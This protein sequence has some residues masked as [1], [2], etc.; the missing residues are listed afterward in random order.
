MPPEQLSRRGRSRTTPRARRV[1]L[2]FSDAEL[3]IVQTA[4][5]RDGM[6]TGAWA[7]QVAVMVAREQLVPGTG[8]RNA[9]RE[10]ITARAELARVAVQWDEGSA[11]GVAALIA[12]AVARVDTA[13]LQ[14]MRERADR[15]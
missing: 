15:S 4:A 3:E 1:N 9:L 2:A 5:A 14:L 8:S 6:A 12:D 10:L 11:G 13:T 7:S